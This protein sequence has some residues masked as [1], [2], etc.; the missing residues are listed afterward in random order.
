MTPSKGSK[1][2]FCRGSTAWVPPQTTV[3]RGVTP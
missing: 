1:R 2:R 3:E